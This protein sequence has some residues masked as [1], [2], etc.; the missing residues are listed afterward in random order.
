MSIAI[1]CTIESFEVTLATTCYQAV[2]ITAA[3]D[4]EV[5]LV[6]LWIVSTSN[7]VTVIASTTNKHLHIS[8]YGITV[9]LQGY[10]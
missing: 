5:P 2:V 9:G 6:N 3:G 4:R 10:L 7:Q 1:L 8:F